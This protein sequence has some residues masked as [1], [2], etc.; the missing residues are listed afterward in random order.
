MNIYKKTVSVVDYGVKPGAKDF[1]TTAIQNAIDDVFLSGG[2]EVVIPTGEYYI[3]TLRL[4]SNVCLHLME[5]VV[6]F[7]S[8]NINDYF[9]LKHDTVEPVDKE[10]LDERRWERGGGQSSIFHK[11]GSRWHNG[12][13]RALDAENISVIGE[14]GSVIDG[15]NCY[16]EDGEEYYRGPHGV[17]IINCK[18]V[19]LRGYTVRH[20]GNW[21]NMLLNCKDITADNLIALA[22]HD[23]IHFT[24]CDDII[25]KN[26]EFYTGDDCV[27]GFDNNNV[28]V[29]NCILNSACS[30]FRM[31][32]N[33][34]LINRCKAYAPAK[35]KFRGRM[36]K[37]DKCKGINAN[38][39]DRVAPAYEGMPQRYNMLSF[40]TYYADYSVEIRK[41]PGNIVVRNCEVEN[42]DRFLHF[43]YSGNELW[44]RNRPLTN[45]TF[46]N[47]KANGI[48]MPLTAYGDK[49]EPCEI[50]L[51]NMVFS[52]RKGFENIDFM[53]IA[54]LSRLTID[55]FEAIT[56][57]NGTFIKKWGDTAPIDTA[58]IY[59]FKNISDNVIDPSVTQA[60]EPFACKMI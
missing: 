29:E 57:I 10:I 32:G 31:G 47:I 34:V 2:G 51:N 39:T 45:I 22:G 5:N 15:Q 33:N 21:A 7:A 41:T 46:E 43:N 40:F 38:D 27:A 6:L 36:T 60:D 9:A 52:F 35:Y 55:H 3:S 19:T 54:N 18:G 59:N 20:S 53:H 49:S 25:I 23:G 56:P 4:R 37:E 14:K 1:Q 13:I 12:V 26:C 24:S 58:P 11:Y 8:R 16:D 50:V 17:S 44:Q 30:A 28:V 42:A 48:S